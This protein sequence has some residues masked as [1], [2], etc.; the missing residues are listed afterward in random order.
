MIVKMLFWDDKKNK[1]EQRFVVKDLT[2][3][4]NL[5]KK[6]WHKNGMQ[7]HFSGEVIE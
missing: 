6:F 4:F 2:H 1:K 3:F 5:L 7:K